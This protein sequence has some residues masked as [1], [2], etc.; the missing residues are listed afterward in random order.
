MEAWM[1][2]CHYCSG[3]TAM[4]TCNGC[5]DELKYFVPE[6]SGEMNSEEVA[7]IEV[8]GG[9]VAVFSHNQWTLP[10]TKINIEN[11]QQPSGFSAQSI[12]AISSTP[13]KVGTLKDKNIYYFDQR[14]LP[15]GQLRQ[16]VIPFY[17]HN[18][19]IKAIAILDIDGNNVIIKKFLH[20]HSDCPSWV[21]EKKEFPISNDFLI[22]SLI[23]AIK[24]MFPN[25][26][27]LHL[28]KMSKKKLFKIT[29]SRLKYKI[30]NNRFRDTY[31][32][33]ILDKFSNFNETTVHNT[34]KFISYDMKQKSNLFFMWNHIQYL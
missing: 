13:Y 24:Y 16:P 23:P 9:F 18:H 34:G 2:S 6:I 30:T 4:G 12:F 31:L 29:S 10:S 14:N 26:T 20:I 5:F 8:N 19:N 11:I 7:L 27:F 25:P 3:L 22:N 28:K 32:Y 17:E 1:T 15:N 21:Q 33:Q